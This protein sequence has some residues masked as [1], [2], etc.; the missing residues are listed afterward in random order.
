MDPSLYLDTARLGQMSPSAFRA[1][2]DFAR[3]ACEHG[4]SL[5][6][7]ELLIGGFSA[8]PAALRDRYPD[9][10][11]W[12]GVGSLAKR[13]RVLAQARADSHVVLASRSATLMQFAARLLI[14]P[15]RNVLL[16]DLT[17]PAYEH[18]F[19]QQRRS[20]SC[21]VT[22][23]AL[24]SSI[25]RDRLP[26]SEV[27]DR[28]VDGFVAQGCDGLFL[29]LVDNLGVRLPV[30]EIVKRI[31]SVAELRFVAVDGAQAIGHVPLSLDQNY[32]DVLIAGCHKWL[33]A[34][35]PMG[36][37]FFGHPRTSSYVQSSLDRWTGSGELDDPLLSF[38]REVTSGA[39]R[40]FGET[41][42]VAPL[43]S[44]SGAVSDAGQRHESVA[45]QT[46]LE[47]IN[48]VA[49]GTGWRMLSPHAELQSKVVIL[50]AP[51]RRHYPPEQLR[52]HFVSQGVAL[53]AYDGGLIR[54]SLPGYSL[55][56]NQ[57]DRLHSAFAGLT[58]SGSARDR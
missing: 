19:Q 14:G 10:G 16:T 36:F 45:P 52:R 33:S 55:E 24:R 26:A 53:T 46:N 22:K 7:S 1:S 15:C 27:V 20:A 4:C 18:I 58:A 38:S 50:E 32:C 3:F 49:A 44:A 43:F 11:D 54:I 13:L 25:L 12:H 6:F 42:S 48:Q 29:P 57:L 37:A 21:G 28:I 41:V 9:L 56:Q 47:L 8:W 31:R 51:N 30:E 5:Y 23:L 17:W 35:N 34:F 2:V 39:V 40:P